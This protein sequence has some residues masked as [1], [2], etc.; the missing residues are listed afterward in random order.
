MTGLPPYT[1]DLA[2]SRYIRPAEWVVKGSD[3]VASLSSL[4]F[5]DIPGFSRVG[6]ESQELSLAWQP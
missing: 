4:S 1:W 6:A 5:W 2:R 3:R